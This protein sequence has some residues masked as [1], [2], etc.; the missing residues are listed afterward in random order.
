ML[1]AQASLTDIRHARRLLPSLV[2]DLP[3]PPDA[4]ST[5]SL[6]PIPPRW[7]SQRDDKRL[8][9]TVGVRYSGFSNSYCRLALAKADL[10]SAELVALPARANSEDCLGITTVLYPDLN[11]DGVADVVQSLRLKSNRYEASAVVPVVY[12]SSPDARSGYCYSEQASRQLSPDELRSAEATRD[13]LERAR[14][15]LGIAHFDCAQ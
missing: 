5:F 8:L 6:S 10:R 9:M 2:S 15:R 14:R 1:G 3:N 11:G 4:T 12:L 13:A 7:S